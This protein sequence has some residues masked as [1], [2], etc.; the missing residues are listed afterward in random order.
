MLPRARDVQSVCTILCN[1]EKTAFN[2]I[3]SSSLSSA[4]TIRSFVCVCFG[5]FRP[6]RELFTYMQT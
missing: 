5:G 2:M 4:A 3:H 6:T 1:Y